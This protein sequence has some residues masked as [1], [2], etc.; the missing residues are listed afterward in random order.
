MD[1]EVLVQDVRDQ[2]DQPDS[3]YLTHTILMRWLNQGQKVVARKTKCVHK[4]TDLTTVAGQN[5]YEI[6]DCLGI[7]QVFYWQTSDSGYRLRHMSMRGLSDF[8][9]VNTISGNP[10]VW[11]DQPIGTTRNIEVYPAP[12]TSGLTIR[13]YYYALPTTMICAVD[14]GGFPVDDPS[15][16]DPELPEEYQDILVTWCRYKLRLMEEDPA[17]AAQYLDDFNREL[18]EIRSAEFFKHNADAPGIAVDYFF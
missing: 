17:Q 9:F 8:G 2:L 14:G 5:A 13:V 11:V 10:R 6:P 3:S 1:I 16:V 15:N 18:K 12:M 4:I 7:K